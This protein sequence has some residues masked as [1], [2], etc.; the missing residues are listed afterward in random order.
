MAEIT[1]SHWWGLCSTVVPWWWGK[2]ARRTQKSRSW[3]LIESGRSSQHPFGQQ[4]GNWEVIRV[5]LS[6]SHPRM[7]WNL[8]SSL[9]EGRRGRTGQR[10]CSLQVPSEGAADTGTSA[11]SF[12]GLCLA[13]PD[14]TVR[15]CTISNHEASKC[16]SF[17]DSMEKILPEA[18]PHVACV[19]RS[20]YLECIKAIMVS[21]CCLKGSGRE[22]I[23][24][25][26]PFVLEQFCTHR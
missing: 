10:G 18:G 19:K 17:R 2:E 3:S 22:S 24:S 5:P 20:S 23:L 13:V 16:S 1:L 21:H 15:W 14:K 9:F 8:Y 12:L 6:C 25:W 7:Q 4:A 26:A 11:L